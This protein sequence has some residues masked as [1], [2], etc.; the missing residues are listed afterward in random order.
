MEFYT[1]NGR[2]RPIRLSEETRAFAHDSLNRRYGLMTLETMAV[3][4][5]D[6]D[7]FE[8]L[9]PLEKYDL[10]ILRIAQNAPVRICENEKLS[11]AATL[12]KAIFHAIP[13]CSSDRTHNRQR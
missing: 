9:S 4:L 13:P 11:G 12:G 10:A 5:D 8:A 2:T 1:Q 6:I 3:S 7:N